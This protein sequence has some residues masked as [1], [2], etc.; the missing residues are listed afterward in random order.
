MRKETRIP[1]LRQL[2]QSSTTVERVSIQDESRARSAIYEY[3]DKDFSLTDATSFTVMQRLG[4]RDAFTF[5]HH[6]GQYGFNVLSS[7]P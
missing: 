5:D 4:I 2:E 1:F 3:D 6:F 7:S